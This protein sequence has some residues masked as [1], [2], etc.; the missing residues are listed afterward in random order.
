MKEIHDI[1][2][3]YDKASSQGKQAVLATVVR[4]EGSSYR[5]P[6][7]R[8][9]VTDDGQITGAI[10]GGCLEGDALNRAL[11]AA[12]QKV[13]KLITYDTTKDSDS[14]FGVQLGCNGI[15]HILFEYIHAEQDHNPIALL[16]ELVHCRSH[17]VIAVQYALE[18]RD[19]QRGTF[20]LVKDDADRRTILPEASAVDSALQLDID[21]VL[22]EKRS[23][24]K[25]VIHE[26]ISHDILLEHIAP[27]IALLIFGAGN[28]AQPLV[29]LAAAL[30]WPVTVID[31][32]AT[33][34][35]ARRFPKAERV[36]ISPA[37]DAVAQLS[38]DAYTV[39]VL[40]THNFNYDRDVLP[41]LLRSDSI[42][43]GLL[44]PRTRFDRL[45]SELETNGSN[46]SGS[47]DIERLFGPV[48]LD[49]GAETSEEIALSIL[50]EIKAV[51]S[52]RAGRSLRERITK[53]HSETPILTTNAC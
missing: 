35:T 1:V 23:H 15:V 18:Q 43:I 21:L 25:E 17:A 24:Q 16:R 29:E 10:S 51:V 37:P 39:A 38:I 26:G 13:N 48:G 19:K 36:L 7:A 11:L 42:Y 41:H 32:R 5:R 3:A 9:L 34:A 40:M 45:M 6:G 14:A 46:K 4:V 12:Y 28:D 2:M 49:I 30:N 53:M 52:H 44:G 27:S 33:H 8:M 50:A 47:E 31:G 20:L 22:R